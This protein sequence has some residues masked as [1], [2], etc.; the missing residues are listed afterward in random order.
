[1][2][3]QR[4]TLAKSKTKEDKPKEGYGFGDGDS[5][6]PVTLDLPTFDAETAT[7]WS[8]GQTPMFGPQCLLPRAAAAEADGSLLVACLGSARVV[9]Y[10]GQRTESY[11]PTTTFS[12]KAEGKPPTEYFTDGIKPNVQ[13]TA[14]AVP[15]GPTGIAIDASGDALVWS[16]F[17]RKLS[18]VTGKESSL[19]VEIPR[20]APREEGWLRGRELFFSNGDHRISTDGRACANCHVDGGDDGL[21]WKTPQGSRRTRMLRGELASGPYGWKGEHAT[22]A[23]HIQSTVKNLGGAGLPDEEIANLGV[24]VS[25]LKSRPAR[26]DGPDVTRGEEL[27]AAADCNG[28]HTSGASDRT[29]HDIG[30]GG[31][32]M[33]P[34]LASSG[35]RR[36][37]MHDGRFKN[38]DDLL[39]QSPGMG[40]RINAH[41]RRSPRAGAVSRRRYEASVCGRRVHARSL[42]QYVSAQVPTLQ[43]QCAAA[44]LLTGWAR[45]LQSLGSMPFNPRSS[46][47]TL[48]PGLRRLA[49]AATMAMPTTMAMPATMAMPT[50]M[51]MPAAAMPTTSEGRVRRSRRARA[52]SRLGGGCEAPRTA[53]VEAMTKSAVSDVARW[54]AAASSHVAMDP[55]DASLGRPGARAAEFAGPPCVGMRSAQPQF[56]AAS[57]LL[58]SEVCAHSP[59]ASHS[60]SGPGF[61]PPHA[62]RRRTSRPRTTAP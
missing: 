59:P 6:P 19:V 43:L 11:F 28:C 51:A 26:K 22:L 20:Q 5:G 30:T 42:V 33:T 44:P 37:L 8:T 47:T 31:S 1:M 29:L 21:T 12:F 16:A 35:T 38:L 13:V 17:A 46:C 58:V 61:S 7:L 23:E 40:H 62:R 53:T 4:G 36:G 49:I 48:R 3:E 54:S 10:V 34:T 56:P 41:T 18:R 15:A 60:S 14:I 39:A 32:F 2:L 9:R 27:F 52:R 57:S 50:T 25:S 24:Y 55:R 45:F